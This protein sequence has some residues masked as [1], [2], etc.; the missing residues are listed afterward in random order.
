M[1]E[2]IPLV[3]L[4]AFMTTK[5]LWRHQIDELADIADIQVIELSNY[6][7]VEGMAGAVLEQAPEKFAL[8][9]LSLG[10][11]TAFKI[12]KA[13][14]E[15]ITRLAL[16]DTTAR[17]DP[18][19]RIEGRKAMIELAEAGRFDEA[20]EPYLQMIQNPENPFTEEVFDAVRDM[21]QKVGPEGLIRQQTAMINRGDSRDGLADISCPTVVICGR[22]DQ[23]APLD[24]SEEIAGAIP[25]AQLVVIEDCGH[26]SA[27]ERPDEVTAIMRDW[28]QA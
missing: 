20:V 4:P 8:A 27:I 23:P 10:G 17:S 5:A 6:D 1:S 9:G 26:F 16:I 28:L 2:K 12:I 18:Q 13:A 11:F 19:E 7:S 3:L 24:H 15:R 25:N 21:A 14:P 22:Q